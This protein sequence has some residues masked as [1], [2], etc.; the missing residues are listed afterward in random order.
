MVW[1]LIQR[2]ILANLMTLRFFV[3]VLTCLSMVFAST[4]VLTND[5][6][7]RSANYNMAVIKHNQSNFSAKTYSYTQL[8]LDRPPNSLS[9]FNQGFDKRAANTVRLHRGDVPDLWKDNYYGTDYDNPFRHLLAKL[10]IISILQ[11]ILSLLAL[12]FAYDAVAGDYEAGTLRLTLVNPVSR[13][14]ILWAKYVGAIVCLLLPFFISFLFSLIFQL[15]SGD[16][17]YT[18]ADFLQIG[19]I[20]VTSVVY[21]STFYLIGLLI[22]C[23]TLHVAASLTLSIF[24]WIVFTLIYP[25][26]TLFMVNRFMDT[27]EKL[28][29]AK[30][31][32]DQ[33]WEQF[34]REKQKQRDPLLG[35]CKTWYGIDEGRDCSYIAPEFELK[36]PA[37]KAY[38][39]FVVPLRIRTAEKAWR[40]R[41]QAI[42]ETYI[43]KLSVA[44]N[45]LRFSPSGLYQLTTEA[46][47]GTGLFGVEDFFTQIREYRETLLNY[48]YDKKAFSSRQWFASDKGEVNWNDVPQFTY[49]RPEVLDNTFRALPDLFLLSILNLVLFF[50]TFVIFIR[51]EI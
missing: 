21:I 8:R 15:F 18:V 28:E 48:F 19:G 17:H 7:Q 51:Q 22:S 2:E 27:E 6:A 12:I 26:V 35:I 24:V 33:I 41:K 39:Q 42:A 23:A 13:G 38:Y 32:V 20:F 10:D 34:H 50:S 43:Q 37:S 47:A 25:N 9:I 1:I 44:R 5:Y 16:I 36:I 4:V 46:W 3:A 30:R 49:Q 31:E 29:Q 11:I 14:L 45:I 40:V